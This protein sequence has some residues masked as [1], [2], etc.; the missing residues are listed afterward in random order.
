MSVD[1]EELIALTSLGDYDSFHRN[2]LERMLTGTC[3]SRVQSL[4]HDYRMGQMRV[5]DLR[6]I[7]H[8]PK[9]S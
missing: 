9:K 8:I 2:I 7:L 5:S 4:I 1:V 6:K 3:S